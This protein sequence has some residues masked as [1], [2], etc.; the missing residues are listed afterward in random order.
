MED[1]GNQD[2]SHR[3]PSTDGTSS[4]AVTYDEQQIFDDP[5]GVKLKQELL[6]DQFNISSTL[7]NEK[8]DFQIKEEDSRDGIPSKV[9]NDQNYHDESRKVKEEP[10]QYSHKLPSLT[11]ACLNRDRDAIVRLATEEGGLVDDSIRQMACESIIVC[12]FIYFGAH[13]DQ[14]QGQYFLDILHLVPRIQDLTKS[15]S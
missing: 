3:E 9:E 1:V 8:D 5:E 14:V 12:I 11:L 10:N 7:T 13:H 4:P 6:D 15:R 2:G